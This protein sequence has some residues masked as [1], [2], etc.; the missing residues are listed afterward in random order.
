[1]VFGSLVAVAKEIVSLLGAVVGGVRGA[2]PDWRGCRSRRS[3]K[4]G[5]RDIEMA[6]GP[7]G[8]SFQFAE[9]SQQFLFV[10]HAADVPADQF[11]RPQ[12]WL[13]AR[14][15][16]DQHAGDNRALHLNFDAVLRMAQQVAASE[17][18]HE[19]AG[20]FVRLVAMRRKPC[21]RSE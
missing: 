5:R 3:G 15:Q 12:G 11:V 17:H 13:T 4:L 16:T 8:L 19:E 2:F 21:R 7:C 14:P 20:T 6:R 9:M 18:M 10:G 1:M